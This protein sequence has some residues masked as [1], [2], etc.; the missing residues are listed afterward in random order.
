MGQ[1]QRSDLRSWKGRVSHLEQARRERCSVFFPNVRRA[2]RFEA[3]DE[4]GCPSVMRTSGLENQ[5]AEACA[6]VLQHT[7]NASD[8]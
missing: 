1:M 2:N 6:A 4:G 5:S 8:V 7:A 3:P